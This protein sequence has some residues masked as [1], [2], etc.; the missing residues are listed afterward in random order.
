[1]ASAL[2]AEHLKFGVSGHVDRLNH[3]WLC[4]GRHVI[5]VCIFYSIVFRAEGFSSVHCDC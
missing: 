5:V 3:V 1:M 2:V 4:F